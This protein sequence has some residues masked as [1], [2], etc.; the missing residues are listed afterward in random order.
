MIKL[1]SE[2]VDI[3]NNKHNV[4]HI[5]MPENDNISKER[6][7]EEIMSALTKKSKKHYLLKTE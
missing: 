2:Y 6:I 5:I 3:K 1:A 4:E 7:L